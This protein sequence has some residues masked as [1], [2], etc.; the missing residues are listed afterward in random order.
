MPS[1]Q[2]PLVIE[3]ASIDELVAQQAT[4][5]GRPLTDEERTVV[6]E[7]AIDDAVL[8]REA[9]K[10]G[11]DR[12]AVVRRHLVHKMRFVLGEEVPEPTEAELRAYLDANR[13]RYRSPPAVTLDHV[14]YADR[15]RVPDGLLAR[16]QNGM[17]IDGLGDPLSTFGKTLPRYTLRDLMGLVGPE[18]ARRVFE[19]PIGAWRGPMPSERGVHFM[20]VAE[21][22]PPGMPSFEELETYL[23]QDWTLD[24]QQRATAARLAGLRR[25]YRIVVEQSPDRRAGSRSAG[26]A[27]QHGARH[28]CGCEV[29]QAPRRNSPAPQAWRR[30]DH[31]VRDLPG[32]ARS[33]RRPGGGAPAKALPSQT[34]TPQV[35]SRSF[36]W[37]KHSALDL[38]RGVASDQVKPWR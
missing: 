14:F 3:R 24:Q 12:D 25:N 35:A 36:L 10:R 22:H 19:A 37:L 34:E 8:L 1:E 27:A 33:P 13:E 6:V 16:L 31:D 21:R 32:S 2:E 38:P 18:V 7:R 30:S 17:P 26:H 23:R 15:A 20:R 11:L 5:L 4:L 9:Y 28:S 29:F